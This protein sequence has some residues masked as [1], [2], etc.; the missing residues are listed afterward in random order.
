[1][2]GTAAGGAAAFIFHGEPG[3]ILSGGAHR[4]VLEE[5]KNLG[6]DRVEA[7]RIA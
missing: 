3:R 5:S 1:M 4:P 7:R 2:A 6:S